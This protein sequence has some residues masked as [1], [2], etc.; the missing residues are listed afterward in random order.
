MTDSISSQQASSLFAQLQAP[1]PPKEKELGK[2]EFLKLLVAQLNNQDPLNPKENGDFIAQLAQF[3]SVEGLDNLNNSFTDLASSL[4]SN[5]ALQASA[6]VGRSVLKETIFANF[7]GDPI[8]GLVTLPNS[9][10]SLV[11]NVKNSAG[12]VVDR[13]DLGAQAAGEVN[14]SF[15]GKNSEGETLA[16]GRFVFEANGLINGENQQLRT[17]LPVRVESVSVNGPQGIVLNVADGESLTLAD[18]KE[19]R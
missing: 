7:N 6:M 4:K 11:V 13:I 9:T 18:V 15:S 12:E 14:F 10:S 16:S 19:I 5:Q 8:E 2:N 3:S 1:T 17:F